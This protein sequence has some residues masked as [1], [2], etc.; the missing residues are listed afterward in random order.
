MSVPVSLLSDS[1]GEEAAFP[2]KV[3]SLIKFM[4]CILLRLQISD[5]GF[6]PTIRF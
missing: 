4:A 2:P 6:I 3:R 5:K 1:F